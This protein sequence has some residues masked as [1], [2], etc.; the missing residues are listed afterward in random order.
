MN[1]PT[2]YASAPNYYLY[3]FDLVESNELIAELKKNRAEVV[4]FLEGI[5]DNRWDFAY[6]QD[7]WTAAQVIRH[8]IE[9]ERIFAYRAL[10]FSRFDS[11]PLA[12]FN[13]NHYIENLKAIPFT[14]LGLINEFKT[15][16]DSTISLFESMTSEMLAYMGEA[17]GLPVNAEMLGFMIVGHTAHHVSIIE[18]RYLD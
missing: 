8:I 9:T 11:T 4:A 2:L 1:N 15:V 16:R 10:R 13:E 12:G 7:K 18:T 14:R 3:Y 5:P 17:N 6:E